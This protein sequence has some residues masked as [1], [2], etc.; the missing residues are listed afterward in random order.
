M[1]GSLCAQ[2]CVTSSPGGCCEPTT[3]RGW[4][5]T[6]PE[7]HAADSG[8]TR[9]MSIAQLALG[10]CRMRFLK[11]ISAGLFV[12]FGA[13]SQVHAEPPRDPGTRYIAELE[14]GALLTGDAGPAVRASLGFGGKWKGFPARFYLIG[15]LGASSYVASPP[16]YLASR[17]GSESGAFHELALGLRVLVP[18]IS[19][20]RVLVE[21]LVGGTLA[22]ASYIEPGIAE[23]HARQWLGLA[24]LSAGLQWR[25]LY[26]F[27]VG[28]RVSLALNPSGLVGV[29]RYAGVHDGGRLA[30]TGG[31]TWHF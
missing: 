24:L 11:V 31:L 12:L 2:A 30:I 26:Q 3:L 25:F 17:M 8:M 13:S 14:G 23:L 6:P 22:S 7:P 16:A 28:A 20:L 19:E 15:Q 21:G 18:V 4:Q 27:S 5:D 9:G 29:A 1:T 10:G